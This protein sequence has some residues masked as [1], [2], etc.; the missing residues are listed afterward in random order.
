MVTEA[1]GGFAEKILE[2]QI[3]PLHIGVRRRLDTGAP[4]DIR[5]VAITEGFAQFALIDVDG[6]IDEP[7]VVQGAQ[8]GSR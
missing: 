7:A 5:G 1:V 2:D 3:V 8:R 4:V 6:E